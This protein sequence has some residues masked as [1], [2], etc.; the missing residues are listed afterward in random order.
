M[1][2]LGKLGL[3]CAEVMHSC[4][5]MIGYD[6]RPVITAL[7]IAGSLAEAV[8]NRQLIFVAVPTPHD[9]AYGGDLPTSHLPP[10][11]FDYRHVQDVLDELDDLLNAEQVVVLIST[12]LP[13]TVRTQL[14]PRL[15]TARLLYNPYLIA[16]GSVKQ[17]MVNPEMMIVGTDSPDDVAIL[18]EFYQPVLHNAP[19]WRVGTWEEAETIKICYN[20]FLS[21]KLT[22]VNM[23]QDIAERNGHIDVDKVTCALAESS[24]VMGPHYMTAGMGDGGPCHVRDAIALRSLAANYD[25]G[26]DLYGAFIEAREGQARNLAQTILTH[27]SS[28]VILGKAYKPGVPFIDGSYSLLLGHYIATFGGQVHYYDPATGDFDHPADASVYVI[29]YWADWVSCFV[30]RPDTTIIDPWRR[31]PPTSGLRVIHYGNRLRV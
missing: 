21:A 19:P 23:I 24:R 15:H 6:I 17:D 29:G 18:Q 31:Y 25:L 14:A 11:D 7:P 16:M 5:D 8:A 20:T 10:K 3:P 30:P 27:G 1:I 9:P 12:T 13:G 4:H 26:Y 2:G 28:V 22:L